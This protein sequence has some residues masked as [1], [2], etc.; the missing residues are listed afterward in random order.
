M[1]NTVSSEVDWDAVAEDL[2]PKVYNFFFYRNQNVALSEDLTAET[3]KR[4]WANRASY[5]ADLSALQ[6]WVFTIA[7]YIWIDHLRRRKVTHVSLEDAFNV[8]DESISPEDNLQH[9][10]QAYQLR[11]LLQT[12][13]D[14]DQEL[15]ALKYGANLTNVE[16]AKLTGLSETN[17]GTRLHRIVRKLREK[18]EALHEQSIK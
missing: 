4:A 17:V 5:R 18:W 14:D 15:I 1:S 7:R 10:E 12:L 11:Q 13:C 8:A 3:L 2:I 16:I 6:T 9:Q